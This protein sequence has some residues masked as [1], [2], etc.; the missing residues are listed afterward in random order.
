MKRAGSTYDQTRQLLQQGMSIDEVARQRGLVKSTIVGHLERLIQAGEDLDLRPLMPPPAR[1]EKIRAAFEES[2]DTLLSPVKA[3]LGYD[4]SY[5]EI[6]LA[7]I[8]LL[9]QED[10]PD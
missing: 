4:Y 8:F 6:R 10:L 7:R 5:D 3:L 2:G 1:F 9:Q